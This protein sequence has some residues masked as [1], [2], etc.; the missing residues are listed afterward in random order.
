MYKKTLTLLIFIILTNFS[1]F[2]QKDSVNYDAIR[3]TLEQILKDDQIFRVQYDSIS[4]KFG[5]D[6]KQVDSIWTLINK[7][8]SA[9]RV[10]VI[11]ILETYGWPDTSQIGVTANVAIWVV[12]QHTP[13]VKIQEKYFPLLQKAVENGLRKEFLAL[14]TD[15]I[16]MANGKKQIYGTQITSDPWNKGK[17]TVYPIKNPEKVDERRKEMGMWELARYLKKWNIEWDPVEHKKISN[18]L[19]REKRRSHRQYRRE[20]KRKNK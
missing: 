11:N 6:S 3:D 16:A 13:D 8:D 19:L 2:G 18:K 12:I 15:R 17:W 10:T 1:V 9:N 4:K 7:K 14:T 5:T 20:Q